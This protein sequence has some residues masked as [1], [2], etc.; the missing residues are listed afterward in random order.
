MG[1]ISTD[2]PHPPPH[3]KDPTFPHRPRAIR[4]ASPLGDEG[5]EG[6]MDGVVVV[7]GGWG[8]E[9]ERGFGMDQHD[10]PA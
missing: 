6:G 4:R 2:S 1:R 3:S 8:G 5:D 10:S 9:E 7:V